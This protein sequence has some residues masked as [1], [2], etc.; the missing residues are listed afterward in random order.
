MPL[1]QQ[2]HIAGSSVSPPQR[3]NTSIGQQTL[4]ENIIY[5]EHLYSK[6]VD[7]SGMIQERFQSICD[8]LDIESAD[9][10]KK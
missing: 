6:I 4:T 7:K 10:Q 5:L 3:L 2:Q 9:L 1:Q 8:Q